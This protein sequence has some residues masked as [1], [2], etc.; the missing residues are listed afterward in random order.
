MSNESND[1]SDYVPHVHFDLIPI[2][3][4]VSNQDYQR[5][6]SMIHVTKAVR[7]FDLNQINPIKV[8]RRDGINYVFNG[9]HTAEIVAM[10]SGSRDTPVWCMIYDDL[11]YTEEADIF[12]NQM[13]NVKPLTAVE[14][15][16]ANCEAGD[17]KSLLIR[18]L[19]ESYDMKI[20]SAPLPGNIMA[21]AAIEAIYDK[22]GYSVLDR[23]LKLIIATWEGEPKSFSANFLNSI[24]R[25]VYAFGDDLDDDV[26]KRKLSEVSI[27]EII[28]DSK[29]RRAGSLG[30]A[31]SMLKVYNKNQRRQLEWNLLYSNTITKKIR[32][33]GGG[34]GGSIVKTRSTGKTGSMGGSMSKIGGTGG[35]T[36]GSIGGS[37]MTCDTREQNHTPVGNTTSNQTVPDAGDIQDTTSSSTDVSQITA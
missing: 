12:A 11:E 22:Y 32:G 18:G 26:F 28:R 13:K 27:K 25:M 34:T 2:K 6:L 23:V 19:I 29:E 30:Y 8:S 7:N 37:S 17:E 1:F 24:T 10:A 14:I 16:N 33:K 9:Q 21:I 4:L 20:G 36:G 31:E 5:D 3:D 15:F 35:S